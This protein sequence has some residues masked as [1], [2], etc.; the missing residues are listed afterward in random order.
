M[1]TSNARLEAPGVP[2]QA[3][4]SSGFITCTS[5][6]TQDS[7]GAWVQA[8]ASTT[9]K[10]RAVQVFASS[11]EL[12]KI[13]L[14]IGV[15]AASSEV[16]KIPNISVRDGAGDNGSFHVLPFEIPS[17]SRIAISV[18]NRTNNNAASVAVSL[19]TLG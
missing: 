18:V 19:T 6:T 12:A 17:G 3:E 9:F 16:V 8:I 1:Y 2:T 4:A 15:G 11:S 10:T 5:D 7:W 13:Q 14:R